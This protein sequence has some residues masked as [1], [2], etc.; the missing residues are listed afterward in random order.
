MTVQKFD[1]KRFSELLKKAM[2]NRKMSEYAH[3]AG[4]SLTYLSELIREQ[5]E[6]QP[7]PPTIK[8]LADK[9]YNGV[10]YEDLMAAAGHIDTD[11][12]TMQIVI[13]QRNNILREQGTSF[14]E[15]NK[16]A[17]A[18]AESSNPYDLNEIENFIPYD[19]AIKIPV[20]GTISPGLPLYADQNII[21][22]KNVP[23]DD[24]KGGEHFF[25]VV[26][27]DSM[28]GSRIYQGDKVLVR[29]QEEIENGQ[30]A[31][32]LVNKEEATLRRVKFLEEA[33]ILYPDNPKYQP[34]VYKAD[35][36]KIL[37][38]VIRVTFEP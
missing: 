21:G 27:S 4:I 25:L 6:N 8:K 5:R 26:K 35:E 34:Q 30:I 16:H 18:F 31:V 9:A 1:K 7:M 33:V 36:V 24:V 13:K 15:V 22:Y 17:Q 29:R 2:G 3:H 38:R 11:D 12:E 32:V 19:T 14:E 37:G 10:T 20:L 23:L 28:I